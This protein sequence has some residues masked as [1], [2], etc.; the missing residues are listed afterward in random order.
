VGVN[1][2]TTNDL[3]VFFIEGDAA[4]NLACLTSS[5]GC[6]S[7]TQGDWVTGTNYP[8]LDNATIANQF[9][10]T[11]YPTLFMI[12]PDKVVRCVS[13]SVT[14]TYESAYYLNL[15]AQNCFAA[16][17]L[18]AGL[19]NTFPQS[20][21]SCDSVTPTIKLTNYSAA[22]LTSCVITYKVDGT[23]QKTINWSGSLATYSTTAINNV[24]VGASSVGTH[25]IT[26]TVSAP[27]GG[28][29][30]VAANNV[31]TLYF[32]ILSSTGGPAI[33]ETFQAG[34]PPA[35]W[36]LQNGGDQTVTWTTGTVGGFGTSTK[37]TTLDFYNS[38]GGDVDAFILA[39]QTFVSASAISMTF[40]LAKA[41]YAGYIDA[42]KVKVSKNCGQT[43]TTVYNKADNTGLSTVT[44]TS[45]TT[46]FVPTAAQWRTET[47]NLN[48]YAGQ[49]SVLVMFE[50]TSGYGNDMFIDNINFA[51]TSG[52]KE[53]NNISYSNLYPNPASTQANFEISLTNTDNVTVKIYNNMGQ[54]VL[55][56]VKNNMPAGDNS[57]VLNT[58]N[59]ANGMYNVVISAK[60]GF[61]AKKLSIAK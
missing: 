49:S 47:V 43:W 53:I 60:Q 3:F 19:H 13:P 9:A 31:G 35:G 23:T 52:I 29:D 10:I 2:G 50:G 48:T 36:M 39:P 18:D 54:L 12:C 11:Y 38:P 51:L 30:V 46:Q 55:T 25:T 41:V 4:T 14:G 17:T 34:F 27:N 16:T 21:M 24:K 57:F 42:L 22:A 1:A 33:V 56:E 61:V 44:A 15:K 20:L 7:T 6:N 26:A 32:S 5:V 45:T 37:S 8:I 40:D 28:S 58:E 59:L